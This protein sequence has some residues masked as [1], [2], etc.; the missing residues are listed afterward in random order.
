MDKARKG[1]RAAAIAHAVLLAGM[2]AGQAG[3][4]PLS[5][6][7]ERPFAANLGQ[8][9]SDAH[10]AVRPYRIKEIRSIDAKDSL[11]PHAALAALDRWSGARNGRRLRWGPLLDLQGGLGLDSTRVVT[12][13]LGGGAWLEGDIGDRFTLHASGQFWNERMPA[14]LDSLARATQ[15]STGEGYA[16]R[17]GS[18]VM[19]GDWN[20]YASWDP[21]KYFNFTLGRGKHFIGEGHRSLFLSDEATA[22]PYL[23]ITTS[24]WRARYVNLFTMMNDIRGAQGDPSRFQRKYAS[25]HYLSVNAS[26][27]INLGLF[28]AIVWSQ[29]DS[30]Y[31]RGFDVNYLNPVIFY[32]PVEFAQG[33]PDNALMGFSASVKAGRRTLFY[34][35][36]MLDEFLLR[37]VRAGDGWY[38]NKQAMQVGV[39]ARDAFKVSGLMLRGE[40]NMVRP[41]MYTHSDTRQNYAHFGQPLAH[42]YGSNFQ[43]ALGQAEWSNG[44]MLYTLRGSMAWLGRDTTYSWGNNIFRP[45]SDRPP[46]PN[47]GLRNYN[48]RIGEA[49]EYNLFQG[50]LQAGWLLDPATATRFEASWISRAR[51]GDGVPTEWEHAFRIGISCWFRNRHAEQEPRY[52][53]N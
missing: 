19:H 41:F 33:S 37:E 39:V 44:R 9:K 47:G 40:W 30:I 8:W 20:A 14:Y 22:Y 5:R 29:G 1:M 2:C 43:E 13:R 4:L 10:T 28:E 23:R 15:V 50:E 6:D 7:V 31:P 32:R 34:M 26:R 25:M 38:A 45:E 53:L 18:T 16:H 12:H 36:L 11:R 42:P 52:V 3:W 27:R 46:A 49:L 35:Q 21:G 51:S 48:F 17:D 24:V